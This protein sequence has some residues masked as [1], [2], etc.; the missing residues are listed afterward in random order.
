MGKQ[1]YETVEQAETAETAYAL[2]R[3]VEIQVKAEYL[4]HDDEAGTTTLRVEGVALRDVD[5]A[6]IQQMLVEAGADEEDSMWLTEMF[7]KRTEAF[8]L[9]KVLARSAQRVG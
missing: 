6:G 7:L 5:W 2:V 1:R 9:A 4:R 8:M 3:S